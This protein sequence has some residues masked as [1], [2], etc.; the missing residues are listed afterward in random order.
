[1]K[2]SPRVLILGAGLVARP[3]IEYLH[4]LG[5][6]LTVASLSFSEPVLETC[7]SC[8]IPMAPLR[9]DDEAMLARLVGECDLAVSLLPATMHPA[10]ARACVA[11]KRS[12]VTT[13]YV[14]DAMAALDGPA[15]AAGILLLN[16]IG[17]DPGIDHMSAMSVIHE[18]RRQGGRV[19]G[20]ESCCGG[21]PAPDANDNP[22]GYKFSWS[23]RGVLLAA[24]NAARYL[25]DGKVVEL[26]GPELFTDRRVAE[27]PGVG[28]LEIY[29][30]RDSLPY[31]EKYGLDGATDM[32]RGTFRYPGHC[33]AWLGLARLG[34]LDADTVRKAKGASWRDLILQIQP[35]VRLGT[36][37]EDVA[38][39][40][41]NGVDSDAFARYRWL[42][43]LDEIPVGGEDRPALDC[44]AD[45]MLAQMTYQPGERDMVVLRH[46][47]HAVFPDP[48][49]RYRITSTLVDFGDPDGDTAMSRTVSLPAA[50]AVR[51]ILEGHIRETGVRI[52]AIPEI[53]GP[54]LPELERI[55]IRFEETIEQVDAEPDAEVTD[56]LRSR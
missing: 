8:A 16:E 13:S 33:A 7:E 28:E 23:P 34:L 46:V 29:P 24:R 25:R 2:G 17:L 52:P 54:V 39:I 20:F 42:G 37:E 31:M 41:G 30:N 56:L 40:T 5:A 50:I 35:T 47:F 10:V 9:G 4:E 43:I 1:M 48:E 15:H 45:R 6:K 55:G 53:F 19:T 14:G 3:M 38:R 32:F 26:P 36:L 27:I 51:R 18:V 22:F 49:R 21:L 11:A 12:L 44:L